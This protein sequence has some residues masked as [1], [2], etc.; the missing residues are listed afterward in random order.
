[1]W[2][3]VD[4]DGGQ[5]AVTAAKTDA[6]RRTLPLVAGT[7]DALRSHR[8]LQAAERVKLGPLWRAGER[9][10]NAESGKAL[11]GRDALRAWHAWTTAAGL[12]PRRFHAGRHTAATLLLKRG[13]PLEVVSAVLGHASL[14]ITADIYAEV[15]TEAKRQAL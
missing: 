15:G 3:D 1:E 6:G 9:V 13:V 8:R 10:F 14:S 4:L 12:G 5:L 11:G 7:A 2:P